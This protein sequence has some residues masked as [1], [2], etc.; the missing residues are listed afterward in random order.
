MYFCVSLASIVFTNTIGDTLMK[1]CNIVN[2]CIFNELCYNSITLWGF[3]LCI[4]VT[5]KSTTNHNR[6]HSGHAVV[7]IH[8]WLIGFPNNYIEH[9]E[10]CSKDQ[11]NKTEIST[12]VGFI[13]EINGHTVVWTPCHVDRVVIEEWLLTQSDVQ[14][15]SKFTILQID[16]FQH[17]IKSKTTYE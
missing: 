4:F 2:Y 3:K 15:F 6:A 14:L 9:E 13:N 12:R 5:I 10:E 1:A 8:S 7:F 11:R 17:C 16:N